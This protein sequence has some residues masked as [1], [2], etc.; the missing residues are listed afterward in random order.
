MHHHFSYHEPHLLD[1]LGKYSVSAADFWLTLANIRISADGVESNIYNVFMC[2][3]AL[4]RRDV[5]E[6]LW[7]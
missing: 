3:V 1:R 4:E 2:S 7:L 6:P 5:V